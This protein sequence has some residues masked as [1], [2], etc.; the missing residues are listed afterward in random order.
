MRA[1]R[2]AI[3]KNYAMVSNIFRIC[4]SAEGNKIAK[5]HPVVLEQLRVCI[6]LTNCYVC[7]NG[8]QAGSVNTFNIS[9]PSLEEYLAL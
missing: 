4:G 3:E 5:K 1:A 9:P 2:I 7:L 6:L 8:D